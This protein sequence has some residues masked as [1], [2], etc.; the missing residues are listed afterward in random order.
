MRDPQFKKNFPLHQR[1]MAHLPD[2]RAWLSNNRVTSSEGYLT[3]AKIKEK[4]HELYGGPLMSR[5]KLR[6]LLRGLGF[7]HGPL[8][9]SYYIDQRK[10]DYVQA[11]LRLF[12][13]FLSFLLDR[14][15]IFMVW[16]GDST[17]IHAN[18][19]PRVAWRD[20][21]DEHGNEDRRAQAGVGARVGMDCFLCF[22]DFSHTPPQATTPSS[23]R[24]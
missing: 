10:R 6:I 18:N 2:F 14:P 17:W 4:I 3:M 5:K 22:L 13:P 24:V 8:V 16:F 12:V 1:L 23:I 19:P 11:H 7:S 15:D 20:E 21:A 9:D